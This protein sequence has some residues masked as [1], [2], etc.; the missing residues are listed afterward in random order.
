MSKIR[1]VGRSEAILEVSFLLAKGD[2]IKLSG[3]DFLPD[4][5][6]EVVAVL[7]QS[8]GGSKIRLQFIEGGVSE[9][10]RR[11]IERDLDESDSVYDPQDDLIQSQYQVDEGD[12]EY[13]EV[14]PSN[15]NKIEENMPRT[16]REIARDV[17]IPV[18]VTRTSHSMGGF[19]DLLRSGIAT[20]P[21]GVSGV[22]SGSADRVGKKV[23][24]HMSAKDHMKEMSV[25]PDNRVGARGGYSRSDYAQELGMD[26]TAEVV[27]RVKQAMREDRINPN[28]VVRGLEKFGRSERRKRRK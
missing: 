27:Q 28:A 23:F 18:Y 16:L 8:Q 4:T 3:D 9:E 5:I 1:L 7:G 20:L 22:F 11:R 2:Q 12:N 6:G 10:S 26:T 14:D 19:T 24:P 17:E 25:P 15:Q 21:G 13:F